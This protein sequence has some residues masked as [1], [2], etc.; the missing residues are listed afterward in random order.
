MDDLELPPPGTL[1]RSVHLFR[2]FLAEQTDPD[3]FYSVLAADSTRETGRFVELAGADV[4][5]VGGGPGYFADA[6]LRAGARYVGIEPDA[7]EMTARGHAATNT[8]RAS[9]LAL[10]LADAAVDLCYSSNVLEHVPDPELMA[11]EMLR[12][13]RPGGTVYLSWTPWLS[14][15][16]GHETG[17]WH[18][19]GG[20]RAADR[21]AR[22]HGH[23]PKNDYGS[24]LFAYSVRRML[25][26]ARAVEA[27]GEARV[28]AV[29]PRYHPAWARWMIRV[30]GVREVVAWN[31]VIVLER[32]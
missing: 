14:P 2:A 17:M 5:D 11:H 32:R 6:F 26:W 12:V 10:P 25:R 18:Y 1:A 31:A 27:A 23:R 20:Y 4:L 24:S 3:R 8:L 15:H 22:R 9:G 7:G 16:G 30:P 28:V 19:L 13:T 29:E 21:Y